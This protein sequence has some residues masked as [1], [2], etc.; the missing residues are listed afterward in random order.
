[1]IILHNK[2]YFFDIS[3]CMNINVRC[4]LQRLMQYDFFDTKFSFVGYER[5]HFIATSNSQDNVPQKFATGP[6]LILCLFT[7][8]E[9]GHIVVER[10]VW[11]LD[12]FQK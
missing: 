1:M 11:D 2:N 9:H 6:T 7:R 8:E 10:E 3:K 4:N 12:S 5:L